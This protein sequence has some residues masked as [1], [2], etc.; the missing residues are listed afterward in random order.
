[1]SLTAKY[2]PEFPADGF[3]NVDEARAW[4]ARFLH[5]SN[6]E[7]R[8]SGI[9]YV[10]RAQRHVGD[11]P[12]VLTARYKIY[13]RARAANPRRWSGRT[14]N[15]RPI[16]AVTLN[17]E[18]DAVIEA[19]IVGHSINGPPTHDLGDNDLDARREIPSP[20]LGFIGVDAGRCLRSELR[21]L[22]GVS[23]D[24]GGRLLTQALRVML[25]DEVSRRSQSHHS[26]H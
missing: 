7:H 15:W 21:Q 23:G 16:C 5:W 4:G 9:D 14:R 12:V 8:H 13:S 19:A 3:A 25:P 1:V 18:R 20:P 6:V 10:T 22:D 11:N 26:M 17:P 24:I 2:R